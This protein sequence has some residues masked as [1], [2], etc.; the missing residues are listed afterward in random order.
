MSKQHEK[1]KK[2]TELARTF[3]H[4]W[5]AFAT[6]VGFVQVNY[7]FEIGGRTVVIVAKLDADSAEAEGVG[8]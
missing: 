6:E 2:V 3:A 5:G 4:D 8:R 1:Y 7:R